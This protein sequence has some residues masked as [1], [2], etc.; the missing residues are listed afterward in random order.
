MSRNGDYWA[1]L[2]ARVVATCASLALVVMC[3]CGN[4]DDG[5][6]IE[7]D[8]PN[9]VWIVAEDMNFEIGAFGD[10]VAVTPR[11]DRL[12]AEGVR[13]SN[14]FATS[15]VCAP[16]RAALITGMYATSI[17][18][19]HMRSSGGGYQPV[20]P[21]QVKT[22]TEYLRAAGYYTSNLG[23]TDYQ[24]SGVIGGAPRT[25][26]DDVNGDW[27]GRDPGQPFFAY[28]TIFVT[29]ESGLFGDREPSTEL[30]QIEVPPY[31]PDTPLV[32]RDLARLYDN[33]ASM[34]TTVGEILDALEADG[35]ADDTIVF[36]FPDNG[37]G[38][39]RDKRWVYDGGIHEPLIIRWPDGRDAGATV[40]R[41]ISFI[42]LP[43][44]V[45]S[46]AGVRIP[47]HMQGRAFLGPQ[48]GPER[49][50][51]FAAADRHDEATDRIR[52]VRD[53]RY[54][55]IRNYQPD[56][57][58]GQD[59]AF[60][61]ISS[62]MQEIFRL[63]QAGTLSPPADWYFRPTKPA[64]ELY[65]TL[66]DP[67]E[68]TNIAGQG[69]LQ[70][71]LMEMRLAHLDWVERTGDLGEVPE[72]ELA[73]R[74]WPGG[75]QPVT[76]PPVIEVTAEGQA[77]SHEISISCPIQGASIAYAIGD[78]PE[79][80]WRLYTGPFSIANDTSVRAVAIRYGF[81]ESAEVILER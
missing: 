66:N 70:P 19:H 65:D 50:Y 79:P 35:V 76:E 36:F 28:F 40:D 58:Y 52:A 39:P 25:N 78:S 7:T 57:P 38:L 44:T 14:V 69:D 71:T 67:Y 37:R 54:K 10:P 6:S 13:Y 81:A 33:V 47:E 80:R 55:Y 48:A 9:I 42:D 43:A 30:S 4:D 72:T 74:Y 17:G 21:P 68:I 26:W 11:L 73:E 8:R 60:R 20:P 63:Q 16:S 23:K 49:Q 41:L 45:L 15:G 59:I 77:G 53:A 2:V 64:E 18:A 24:F 1:Q 12:A 56:T 27:R 5:V 62:T 31:Y 22:F 34:D 29:H 61:N 75:V 3:G 46:L 51:I 32:R